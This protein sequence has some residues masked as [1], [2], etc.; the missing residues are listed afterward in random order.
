MGGIDALDLVC[1]EEP[2]L[3]QRLEDCLK[4]QLLLPVGQ[5]PLAGVS[6]EE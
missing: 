1:R 4:E 2:L 6:R 3:D 5:Q